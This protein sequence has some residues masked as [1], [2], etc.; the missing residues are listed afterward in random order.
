MTGSP[1]QPQLLLGAI[2]CLGGVAILAARAKRD[3][4]EARRVRATFLVLG[5]LAGV[6][7][8]VMM[9]WTAN[10][11]VLRGAAFSLKDMMVRA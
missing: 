11:P 8:L 10:L 7:F 9:N 5:A 2:A 4:A 3:F 1:F 6:A